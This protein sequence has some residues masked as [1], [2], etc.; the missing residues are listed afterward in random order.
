MQREN[1]CQRQP[2]LWVCSGLEPAAVGVEQVKGH[3]A[4]E[5]EG[6]HA[7]AGEQA[8]H[9]FVLIGNDALIELDDLFTG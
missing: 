5:D 1:G 7:A 9:P 8:D 4:D 2:F 3:N 6:Q